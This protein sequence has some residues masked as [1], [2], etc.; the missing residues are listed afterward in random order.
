MLSSL[1]LL[2][3]F[4][5]ALHPIGDSLAVF[6]L[7]AGG[8]TIL[9]AL[10][11]FLLGSRTALALAVIA[12]AAIT[13]AVWLSAGL[14]AQTGGNI[15]LYQKNL[16]FRLRDPQ[17]IIEDILQS[18]ADVVTLQE[19]TTH[20]RTVLDG[21]ATALPT[22]LI[23]PFARVGGVAV[24]SHYPVIEGSKTCLQG[25]GLAAMQVAH[26]DGPLWLVSIHLHWPW[27]Y[28]QA[29]Q[30]Q[31]IVP[32]LAEMSGPTILGG[33]FNMVPWSDTHR[34]IASATASRRVGT[35]LNSF[36][37]F[38]T[39]LPLPIDHVF[40]PRGGIASLRPLLGSDHR[41]LLARM[42]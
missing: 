39:L 12:G 42:E 3:G 29:S 30:M 17:P 37:R 13:P 7:Q 4:A 38:G 28:G 24:A 20:N 40:S 32:A 5:G 21:I 18:G 36:P 19:V 23:C 9:A 41:G 35:A 25:R 8:A 15:V 6:R 22:Q 1:A 11:A 2:I 34:Q 10:F 33:D 14:G 27:P 16:S 26:P 31:H